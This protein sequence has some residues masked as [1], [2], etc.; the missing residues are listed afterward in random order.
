MCPLPHSPKTSL[1]AGGTHIAVLARSVAAYLYVALSTADI[2]K[3]SRQLS[4]QTTKTLMALFKYVTVFASSLFFVKL[5]L[6]LMA[7]MDTTGSALPYFMWSVCL[8]T[9]I[10]TRGHSFL[11]PDL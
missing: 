4:L 9:Y 10:I 5:W 7:I 1:R 11:L 8:C 2:D 3:A 6:C